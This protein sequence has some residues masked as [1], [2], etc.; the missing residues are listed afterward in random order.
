M[1]QEEERV[2]RVQECKNS[3]HAANMRLFEEVGEGGS[4]IIQ[5]AETLQTAV[6]G[7]PLLI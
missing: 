1:V 3:K 2:W 7:L 4:V 6:R 5:T